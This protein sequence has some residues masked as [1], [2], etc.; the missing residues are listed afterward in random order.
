MV[1]AHLPPFPHYL[2]PK[3]RESQRICANFGLHSSHSAR[4]TAAVDGVNP[5]NNPAAGKI[6]CSKN[7]K[8]GAMAG[9]F[10]VSLRH[11][12]VALPRA[13]IKGPYRAMQNVTGGEAVE[14][15]RM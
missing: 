2:R 15:R 14:T 6:G 10:S 12:I 3:M 11:L 5:P 13:R 9:A 7:E 1:F 4:P 8:P